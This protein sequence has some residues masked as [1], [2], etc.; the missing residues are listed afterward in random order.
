LTDATKRITKPI[1]KSNAMLCCRVD[2]AQLL[3]LLPKLA[4]TIPKGKNNKAALKILQKRSEPAFTELIASGV[5]S[6]VNTSYRHVH[7]SVVLQ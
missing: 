3:E 5:C 6:T 1:L 2:Q 7:H 4:A